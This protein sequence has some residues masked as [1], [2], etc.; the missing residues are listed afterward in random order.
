MDSLEDDRFK[1]ETTLSGG[2]KTKLPR[3]SIR[4]GSYDFGLRNNPP[5]VGQDSQELLEP[6]GLSPDEVAELKLEKIGVSFVK[7]SI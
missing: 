6:I 2:I 3:I 4:I 5:E 7:E 1:A